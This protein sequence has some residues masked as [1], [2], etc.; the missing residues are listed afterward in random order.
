[1]S[2]LELV[3]SI[4]FHSVSPPNRS[5]EIAYTLHPDHWGR[6]IASR[7]CNA[8]AD[9]G[10]SNQG[11]VRI[12][13]TALDTNLVSMRVLEKC[14][15]LLEGKLRNFRIVRGKPRDFWMYSRVAG[16]HA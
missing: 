15:F 12:Q 4:G 13:G 6:G 8:V 5:A 2:G 1:V 9:W 7:C 14:G 11:Y 10:F 3:G 16:A